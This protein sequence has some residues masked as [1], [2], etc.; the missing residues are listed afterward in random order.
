[1]GLAAL[2][3]SRIARAL[4]SVGEISDRFCCQLL[5]GADPTRDDGRRRAPARAGGGSARR[6]QPLGGVAQM[7]ARTLALLPVLPFQRLQP[8][9]LV[10]VRTGRHLTHVKPAA[11]VSPPC[12]RYSRRSIELHSIPYERVAATAP[13]AQRSA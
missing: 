7:S 6:C 4:A 12:S 2:S 10:A 9:Q 1:M 13:I 5:S 8:R 11:A 3:C